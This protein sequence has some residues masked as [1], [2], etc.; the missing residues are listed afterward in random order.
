MDVWKAKEIKNMQLGGNKGAKEFYDKNQMFGADGVP[1]HKSPS[2]AKYKADLAR[3]AE[4]AL[5]VSP[6]QA[7]EPKE[8][9]AVP[10]DDPF[11]HN[12][13]AQESA[14]FTVPKSQPEFKPKPEAKK[15]IG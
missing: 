10:Q 7:A 11:A 15:E 5:G 9:K 12:I 1:N 2:L 8:Q 4:A 13:S 3:R 14:T 6:F